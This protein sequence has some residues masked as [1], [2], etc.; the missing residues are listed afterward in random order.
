MTSIHCKYPSAVGVRFVSRRISG[1]RQSRTAPVAAPATI[2]SLATPSPY[3]FARS[4]RPAP[5][6]LPTRIAPP[7]PMPVQRQISRFLAMLAI[8]L[9]ATASLPIWPKMTL[10]IVKPTPQTISLPRTGVTYFQKSRQSQGPSRTRY[11]GRN[12]TRPAGSESK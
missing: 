9:A 8:E 3:R 2:E 4:R 5:S 6:S 10:P 11:R 7:L 12:L 1:L